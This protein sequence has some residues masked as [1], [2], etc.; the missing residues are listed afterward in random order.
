VLRGGI[1]DVTDVIEINGRAY[2]RPARP[3]VVVCVDGFDPA[4]LDHG[5]RSG[6]LPTLARFQRSGFSA[7]AAAVVPTTTNP[8]N[9]SIVTGVPP[10]VH[11]INGNFYLDRQTGAEVM[12]VDAAL[13]RCET[14]LGV[15]SRAG[16]RTVAVTAKD[17]LRKLLGHRMAGICFSAERA[18]QCSLEEHGIEGVERLV[19]RG[20]PDQYSPDLSLFVLDAGVRL[21]ERERPDLMYLS[22]SDLVQHTY[23]PEDPVAVE[24]HRQVD[25]RIGRLQAMGA[26]VGVVADHG[27]NDKATPSG[28]PNVVYLEDEMTARFG[29]GTARVICPI[30]DP[31]VRHHGALGSFVRVYA[32]GTTSISALGAFLRRTREVVEVL[33]ADAACAAYELP[34]DLEADLVVLAGRN[35]VLGARRE[36]HDLRGLVGHR[37]RSHGG[38]AERT[39]PFLLS[40]PLNGQYAAIA[41]AGALRNYDIF[42][43]ALNG[44][45]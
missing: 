23:A 41:A 42:A 36:D 30:A 26:T 4:Y 5:I 37:L 31:F 17:K 12:I 44:V 18:D 8:N 11:G 9:T 21:L 34:R 40:H 27:M 32:R 35:A 13:L 43:F 25:E 14:I 29:A 38:L 2:R 19:G 1:S 6:T 15:M 28:E 45:V 10:K 24:F 7:P 33:D 39:V 16:F 3:T 20:A 22:L